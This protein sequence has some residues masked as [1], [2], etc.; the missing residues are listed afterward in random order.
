MTIPE[1][2]EESLERFQEGILVVRLVGSC[3]PH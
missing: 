2:R 3:G 1:K